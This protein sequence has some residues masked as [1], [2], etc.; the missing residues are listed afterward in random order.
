MSKEEKEAK[1]QAKLFEKLR[2]MAPEQI[3]AYEKNLED[4]RRAVK[5]RKEK[6]RRCSHEM[7]DLN[8][9]IELAKRVQGNLA[10]RWCAHEIGVGNH[11]TVFRVKALRV[12]IK[13][14][15]SFNVLDHGNA[16]LTPEQWFRCNEVY[17]D[18]FQ[19]APGYSMAPTVF[20]TTAFGAGD[21]CELEN[22]IRELG[23]EFK[24]DR[25]CYRIDLEDFK[26]KLRSE[27]DGYIKNI[28][29]CLMNN[30]LDAIKGIF[31]ELSI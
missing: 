6:F 12:G 30:S 24:D 10:G 2:E 7:C 8:K 29:G 9:I 13:D 3:D 21:L 5:V 27:R 11:P 4:A 22:F 31:K 19:F 28:D 1:Q 18:M 15:E 20:T 16:V 14:G 26:A 25:K 23:N 17:L